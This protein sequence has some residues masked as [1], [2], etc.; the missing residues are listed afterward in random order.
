MK[1]QLKLFCGF[2]ALALGGQASAGPTWILTG[3]SSDVSVSAYANTGGTNNHANAASNG[4]AQT[5][6]AATLVPYGGGLGITNADACNWG[7]YCDRKE[8]NTPEHSID[9]QQRYDMALLTFADQ[10]KLT[11]V[12][13]GW[14]SNDSDITVLAYTGNDPFALNTNLMGLTYGQLVGSGWT[15][16][17]NYSDVGNWGTKSINSE[18]AFSSYWLIGA[19]NPLAAPSGGAVT[20]NGSSYD[21][22]KLYSV[23]GDLLPPLRIG[24]PEP[25]SW[26]LTGLALIALI[27]LRKRRPS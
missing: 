9:N 19:Y 2:L 21:Y 16:I 12:G 8:T 10:V 15:A 23:T 18:G 27:G 1:A 24:V 6:Q 22:V 3:S 20:G 5:I 4:A 17:G 26:A 14:V 25:S 13:I 11:E 7:H